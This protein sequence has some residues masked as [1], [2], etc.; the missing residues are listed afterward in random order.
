M[1]HVIAPE[2]DELTPGVEGTRLDHGQASRLARSRRGE[3]AE[4][5]TPH[6]PGRQKHEPQNRAEGGRQPN[7]GVDVHGSP[8]AAQR[9][10]PEAH[11]VNHG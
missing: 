2:K 4:A 11:L 9:R 1:F 8:R 7:E 5:E 10:L 3:A 6:R